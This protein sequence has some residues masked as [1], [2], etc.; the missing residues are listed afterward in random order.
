V[1]ICLKVER[2]LKI[3]EEFQ[4]KT[5]YDPCKM[6]THSLN[7]SSKPQ[8]YKTIPDSKKIKLPKPDINK[9]FTL[10]ELLKL[11][12]S[13]REYKNEPLSIA[14]VSNLLWAA[15]GI[16]RIEDKYQFRTAPSAGAL[17][18][19]ET[20]I[21]VNNI[22]GLDKGIYHY[23]IEDHKLEIVLLGNYGGP[24]AEAALGQDMCSEAPIVFV[25][26]A[27]FQRSKWKYLQRAYRYI[28]LDCGH[29]AQNLS[30]AVTALG[31]GGCHIAAFYDDKL[32]QLLTLDGQEESAIYLMSV[33]K[34]YI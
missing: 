28:Y 11:R 14:E 18:P 9:S 29:I 4:Q 2:D 19:I 31:L 10:T 1:V 22:T 27:I 15:T 24:L 17:Y 13:V 7:W 20:Y 8:L 30:L 23:K 6:E 34:S 26:T 25:F 33:G 16:S 3:G 21:V 5:K 12:K 32:N